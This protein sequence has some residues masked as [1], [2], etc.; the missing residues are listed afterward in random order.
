MVKQPKVKQ[1]KLDCPLPDCLGVGFSRQ[2]HVNKHLRK[3]HQ[4][5]LEKGKA[6]NLELGR[7]NQQKQFSSWLK[8]NGYADMSLFTGASIDAP[9][10]GVEHDE[11]DHGEEDFEDDDVVVAPRS[12]KPPLPLGGR[13]KFSPPSRSAFKAPSAPKSTPKAISRAQ[14]TFLRSKLDEQGPNDIDSDSEAEPQLGP[15]AKKRRIDGEENNRQDEEHDGEEE[16]PKIIFDIAQDQPDVFLAIE[17]LGASHKHPM[18]QQ[19]LW[20]DRNL[21]YSRDALRCLSYVAKRH[22]HLTNF[23][24]FK[25]VVE[26]D[27]YDS[28]SD[29]R[30]AFVAKSAEMRNAGST[31][32]AMHQ[33]IGDLQGQV[34]Q[35]EQ[36]YHQRMEQSREVLVARYQLHDQ[37]KTLEARKTMLHAQVPAFQAQMQAP[38]LRE[39]IGSQQAMSNQ[40]TVPH[41]AT[42]TTAVGRRVVG[43][44]AD[45]EEYQSMAAADGV[46]EP[47]HTENMSRMPADQIQARAPAPVGFSESREEILRWMDEELNSDAPRES[48]SEFAMRINRQ[49]DAE[50]RWESPS[51]FGRYGDEL[52]FD[53]FD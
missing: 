24:V 5:D 27:L 52:M 36:L 19:A 51:M 7:Q 6:D 8:R 15:A 4:V 38:A 47:I 32:E 42:Q 2:T 46:G 34:T 41:H 29:I 49:F 53:E 44:A 28:N 22:P 33:R 39:S 21:M 18:V 23:A 43:F 30:N 12:R 40:L 3:T 10:A 50:H 37:I 48:F 20:S 17:V 9:A 14:K 35:L 11:D 1:P 16:I 26:K 13:K 45:E 31:I 25:A